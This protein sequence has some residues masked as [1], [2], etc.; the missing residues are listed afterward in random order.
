MEVS[1]IVSF[2][3][4]KRE[5]FGI[6]KNGDELLRITHLAFEVSIPVGWKV[7]FSEMV[8]AVDASH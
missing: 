8:M 7:R 5:Q 2:I 3:N 1:S 6:G 4:K